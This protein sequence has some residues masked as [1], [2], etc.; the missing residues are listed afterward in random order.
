[1]LM[2]PT[3]DQFGRGVA[4][5]RVNL[6]DKGLKV[7]AGKSKVL[8]GHVMMKNY[9]DWVKKCMDMTELVI[10]SEDIHDMNKLRRNVMKWKSNPIEKLSINR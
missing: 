1:M 8:Y 2:A 4:E 7:N 5:W 6:L 9:E 10:D 3:M